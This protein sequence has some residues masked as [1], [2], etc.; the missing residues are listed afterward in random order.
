MGTIL[1]NHFAWGGAGFRPLSPKGL[2][3]L[4]A[5]LECRR[6]ESSVDQACQKGG[7]SAA[8]VIMI[9]MHVLLD[10]LFRQDS[11]GWSPVF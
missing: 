2:R 1:F 5:L 7:L 6:F 11:R 9:I 10:K 4:N 3:A 8:T